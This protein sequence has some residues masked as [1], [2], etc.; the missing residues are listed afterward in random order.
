MLHQDE[1]D[2]DDKGEEEPEEEPDVDEL[3]VGRG[4][5][6]R[7]DGLVEGVH[8]QHARD[9]HRDARLEMLFL[10]IGCGLQVR[11]GYFMIYLNIQKVIWRPA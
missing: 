4:R 9:C 3:H 1:K 11:G 5:Q 6:L 8:H 7:G 2:D 10:E